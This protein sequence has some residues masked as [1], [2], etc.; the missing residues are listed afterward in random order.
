MRRIPSFSTER[1]KFKISPRCEFVRA[2]EQASA[3]IAVNLNGAA[4]DAFSDRILFFHAAV[5]SM[6]NATAIQA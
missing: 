4:D 6:R 5:R 2:L 3:Q 1:L